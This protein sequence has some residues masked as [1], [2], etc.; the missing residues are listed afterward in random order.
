MD[1]LNAVKSFYYQYN[2]SKK[3]KSLKNCEKPLKVL[4]LVMENSKWCCQSI[5]D[6]MD[7]DSM[8]EP[9]IAVSIIRDAHNGK[10]LSRNILEENYQFFKARNMNV[11]YAYRNNRYVDLRIF[12]PDI[13]FYEQPWDIPRLH[14]PLNVSGFAL[15]CYQTYG[16][17]FF[18]N[19]A[20]YTKK[21]HKYL[22]KYF[23]ENAI[24]IERFT[25]LDSYASK[26]CI[27]LGYSKLDAY[28]DKS[29]IDVNKYWKNAEKTKVIYAPHHSVGKNGTTIATFEANGKFILEYARNNPDITWIFKPHPRFKYALLKNNIMSEEE[30]EQY[31]S[32]WEKIGNIYNQGDYFDI[33]KSSDLMITDSC[34]FL[35]EYMPTQKPIIRL[36]NKK[37]PSSL[38]NKFGEHISAACYLA[39]DNNQLIDLIEKLLVKKDD[40]KLQERLNTISY[41]MDVKEKSAVKICNYLKESTKKGAIK[42]N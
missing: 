36:C 41:L 31:Y 39:Y 6:E 17:T 5:Y 27:D 21:F 9:L 37:N 16:L 13:V 11:D 38:L 42:I 29:L 12:S 28:F 22:W 7:K 25:N 18:K 40:N 2:Y 14:K 33:F 1:L 8:F 4:F 23:A 32:E 15:T 24:E 35:G 26:N 19:K 20:S 10:D 3:L 30:I 34:S